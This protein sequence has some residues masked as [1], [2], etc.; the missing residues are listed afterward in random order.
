MNGD[1]VDIWARPL[2]RVVLRRV[3]LAKIGSLRGWCSISGA[4]CLARTARCICMRE[5][6]KEPQTSDGRRPG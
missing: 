6:A 1:D 3:D 2:L 5:F 4:V